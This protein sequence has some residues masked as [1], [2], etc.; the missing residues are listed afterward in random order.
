[1]YETG[2]PL[3]PQIGSTILVSP[4]LASATECRR[5]STS[6]E[7]ASLR[8]HTVSTD[9]PNSATW[10]Q[11]NRCSR[12]SPNSPQV[13]MSHGDNIV[14]MPEGFSCSRKYG[15]L[16]NSGPRRR[17]RTVRT[18]VPPR[19]RAHAG[20]DQAH[21]QLPLRC[22]WMLRIVDSGNFVAESVEA[23]SGVRSVTAKSSV[24]SLEAS[25]RRW[26]LRSYMQQL[27]TS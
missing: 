1:M 21:S 26:Q 12:T 7:D 19:S 8:V 16:A 5:W 13:W 25:T 23:T 3:A 20:G 9:T 22:L 2:A 27:E 14:E 24:P 6:S 17:C 10:H 11:G 15:Q 18:S 4:S